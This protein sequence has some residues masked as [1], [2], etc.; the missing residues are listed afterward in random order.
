[1]SKKLTLPAAGRSP[2]TNHQRF[3]TLRRVGLAGLILAG[4]VL[5]SAVFVPT[6]RWA[7]GNGF[8]MTD[9]EAEIRPSV[10]GAIFQRCVETGQ[11]VAKG[12]LLIQ[13]AHAP[14]QAAHQQA[15][16]ELDV[17]KAKLEQQLNTQKLT[18]AQQQAQA[19]RARK[20]LELAKDE[21]K[22][23]A[24][25]TTGAFSKRELADAKL[26]VQVAQSKLDEL[27]LP[28]EKIYAQRIEVLRKEVAARA[29]ALALRKAQLDMRRICS[30]LDGTVFFNDFEPGEVVKPE[31]VL[32]QVFDRSAW[33]VKLKLPERMVAYVKVG[34]P[35]EVELAAYPG[36]RCGYLQARVIKVLPVITPQTTGNGI[37][38]IEAKIENPHDARLS[39][40]MSASGE[41]D[42]GQTNWL[43]RI[44]DW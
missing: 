26:K 16:N 42:T 11:A 33:I 25:S 6:T 5:L 41:I 37:F 20:N 7:Q 15:R 43:G 18:R 35:V 1:M 24:E 44:M 10:T 4:A 14:Q 12:D 8:V 27:E 30:P 40:G 17:A 3:W 36:W 23:M 32:G 19:Y 9:D 38:Y 31:H 2:R 34:Q 28:R 21:L 13:L 29:K 22:R 39:P